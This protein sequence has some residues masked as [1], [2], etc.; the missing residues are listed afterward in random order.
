MILVTIGDKVFCSDH[1]PIIITLC[2]GD[3]LDSYCVYNKDDFTEEQVV[4]MLHE[5]KEEMLLEPLPD[6]VI[7]LH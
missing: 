3:K 6:N 7:P 1:E 5:H 2:E 4:K